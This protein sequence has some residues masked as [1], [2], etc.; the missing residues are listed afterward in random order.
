MVFIFL[1]EVEALIRA[2][3]PSIEIDRVSKCDNSLL[4]GA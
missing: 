1:L 2:N 3:E 4:F